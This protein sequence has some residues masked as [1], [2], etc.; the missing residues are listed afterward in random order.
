MKWRVLL[1]LTGANGDVE[2]GGCRRRI[3]W[4]QVEEGVHIEPRPYHAARAALEMPRRAVRARSRATWRLAA[5]VH[6][7]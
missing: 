2:T 3:N 6:S 1:E 7:G 5:I 4:A